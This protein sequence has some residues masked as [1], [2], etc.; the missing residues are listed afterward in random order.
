MLLIRKPHNTPIDNRRQLVVSLGILVVMLFVGSGGFYLL[1]DGQTYF[2]TVYLT[3]LILTTVGMKEGDISLNSSQQ[4]TWSRSFIDG[5]LRRLFGRRQLQKKIGQLKDHFIVC[6]FGRMGQALCETLSERD[7]SFLLI[8]QNPSRIQ[9]A[10]R[11]G[12]LHL[13]GDAMSEQ[14]LADAQIERASG[15][16]SCLGQDADN[17]FVTL[18][19]R[20]LNDKIFIISRSEEIGAESKLRRAGANRVICPSLP[21]AKR[22][23]HMLIQ[24]EIDE[25]LKLT[26]TG[27]DLSI[28]KVALSNLPGAVDRTLRKLSLPSEARLMVV[29]TIH[30]DSQRK[31]NP[32]PNTKLLI[33]DEIIVISPSGG[34]D[35]MMQKLGKAS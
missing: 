9:E 26:V 34:A 5:E 8:E 2:E 18:T 19:V 22:I 1:S 32:L 16:A 4:A 28:S 29:A 23:T 25:L 20:G 10:D 11:L 3:A 14:V 31:F 35:K 13:Q 6:G 12:Y 30:T 24:P 7:A 33:D 21:G 27:P 15:L 17:V